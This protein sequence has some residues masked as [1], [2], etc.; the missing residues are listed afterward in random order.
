MEHRRTIALDLDNAPHSTETANRR[1]RMTI[2]SFAVPE[3]LESTVVD[4]VRERLGA[5]GVLSYVV[6]LA[7]SG[8]PMLD[9]EGVTYVGEDEI[10]AAVDELI[11]AQG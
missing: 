8:G 4:R 11:A 5:V 2:A 3:Q 6:E 9:L 1:E 7:G 10:V